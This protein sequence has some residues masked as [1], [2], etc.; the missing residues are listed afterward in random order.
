MKKKVALFIFRRDFRIFDNPGLSRCIEWCEANNAT[1]APCFIYSGRQVNESRNPYFSAFAFSAMQHFID[2]LDSSLNHKLARLYTD[3]S[4]VEVLTILN[5]K[6]GFDAI[7]FNRDVTPFAIKRDDEIFEWCSN[8][9]IICDYGL[10]G[11]GY[12]IWPAGTILT[13]SGK[14]VPKVFSAFY[15]YTIDMRP[16]STGVSKLV[17]LKNL[18][19]ILTLP[20]HI[21]IDYRVP[22]N[23]DIEIPPNPDVRKFSNYG[24]TRDDY[25]IETTR[26]SIFLKFGVLSTRKILLDIRKLGVPELERQIIWREFY[27]HLA[28]GYPDI[29]ISPNRHIRPDRQKIKWKPSDPKQIEKWRLGQTG[30]MLVDQAMQTLDKEG[31]IHNRLRMV[32]ATYLIKVMGV[33]WRDGERVMATML[34]DYDPAQNSGGWQSMDAQIPGQEISSKTQL[35]KFGIIL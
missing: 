35:R 17:S 6:V 18:S 1:L 20:N 15:K 2:K 34:M 14:T 32:V 3:N 25:N 11:D 22:K 10:L 9:N 31:W 12:L 5:S 33:D 24:K 23:I 16:I 27:Y 28:A 13:K 8:N 4:D 30:D 21:K 19:E 7:F 26:L 29:L